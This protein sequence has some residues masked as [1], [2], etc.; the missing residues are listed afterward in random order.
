MNN[1]NTLMDDIG[2]YS[3]YLDGISYM[4]DKFETIIVDEVIKKFNETRINAINSKQ[5]GQLDGS[6][7]FYYYLGKQTAYEETM[8]LIK[9]FTKELKKQ[10]KTGFV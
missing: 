10:R 9:D 2:K 5:E 7:G 8:C 4:L 3:S 1:I 6:D